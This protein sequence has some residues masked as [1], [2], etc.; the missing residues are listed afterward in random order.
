LWSQQSVV[1]W[2]DKGGAARGDARQ[3]DG[4]SRIAKRRFLDGLASPSRI[5]LRLTRRSS[6]EDAA[7]EKPHRIAAIAMREI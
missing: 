2:S 3:A 4:Q 1:N 5:A 7:P 6:G